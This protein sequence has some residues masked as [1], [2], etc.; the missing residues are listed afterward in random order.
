[1]AVAVEPISFRI[2]SVADIQ[3]QRDHVAWVKADTSGQHH[4]PRIC[5]VVTKPAT[6][7]QALFGASLQMFD[8]LQISYVTNDEIDGLQDILSESGAVVGISP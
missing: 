3:R 7:H 5:A 4:A 2:E 1:L 6:H 8:E